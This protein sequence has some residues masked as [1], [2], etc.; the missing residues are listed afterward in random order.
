MVRLAALFAFALSSAVPAAAQTASISGT[1]V[2]QT[3]AGVPGA[4]VLLTGATNAVTTS[5]SGGQYIF[6]NVAPGTYSIEV[7]LVGFSPVVR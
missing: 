4:T 7:R 1:V 5:G 6:R 2:D 3:G